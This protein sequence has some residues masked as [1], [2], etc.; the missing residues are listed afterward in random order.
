MGL[1]PWF[2]PHFFIRSEDH[3]DSTTD[4]FLFVVKVFFGWVVY[5][6]IAMALSYGDRIYRQA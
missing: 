2:S 4:V 1:F 5:N 6:A 3:G